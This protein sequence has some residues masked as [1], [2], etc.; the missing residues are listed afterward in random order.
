MKR[1]EF[2]TLLGGAAAWPLA[3]RAQQGAKV[4]RIGILSSSSGAGAALTMDF[5]SGLRELGFVE[6][7]NLAVEYRFASG[8]YDALD[9]LA[10][11]LVRLKMD[12]IVTAATPAAKA[13]KKATSTIPIVFI[14]P[15]DPVEIGLVASLARPGGNITGES[16]I[17]PELA[18]KRL[19]LLKETVPSI[20]RVAI[21][22]N[23]VIPPGEV[24]LHELRTA[25]GTLKIEMLPLEIHGEQEIERAFET[26][27]R[28]RAD[29]LLVFHDPAMA[30]KAELITSLAIKNRLPGMFW[31][32]PYINV[33][34]LMSYGPSYPAMFH[35]AGR[36][37][38]RI[39]KGAKPA[40]LPVQAPTRYKTVLNLGA[41]KA[42]GIDVPP[43]LLA[44]TDEVIE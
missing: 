22:W 14:D 32:Q 34:G 4:A 27:V 6:R 36:Y 39:L 29:G 20:S 13:A 25:A 12:V 26:M 9:S 24:A 21:L 23:S 44:I 37:V 43:T 8:R 10:Q 31:D 5:F 28:E 40:D 38:G 30:E 17:A 41:A 15:G 16:S 7:R 19:Q 3:A 18:G 35:R 11:D 1:R 42:L 2:I 33:G